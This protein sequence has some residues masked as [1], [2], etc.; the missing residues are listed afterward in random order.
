[1]SIG[2]R[3]LKLVLAGVAAAMLV[4]VPTAA[5]AAPELCG[6]AAHRGDHS[7]H[8]ENSL[9]AMRAAVADKADYLELD[10]RASSDNR[11]FL[12]HDRTVDR[13]TDGTGAVDLKTSAQVGALH[14]DDGEPVPTLSQVLT[15]AK[16]STTDVLVELKSMGGSASFRTLVRRI[17]DFGADRVRV[18]SFRTRLLDRVT[19]LAPGISQ[20]I[21]A[22]TRLTPA[23]VKPYDSVLMAYSAVTAGWLSTMTYPVFVWTPSVPDQWRTWASRV[24]GII[25]DQPAAFEEDRPVA[26]PSYA[27]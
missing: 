16:S 18:V 8:T 17:R 23:Q 26:C 2:G 1:M 6:V 20:G 27:G 19:A 25:T 3:K 10:V 24:Q 11:L 12:M 5:S 22:K 13:T 4:L 14:L 7:I 9:G 21:L 15:M